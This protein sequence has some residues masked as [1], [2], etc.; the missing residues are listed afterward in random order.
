MQKTLSEKLGMS[1][2]WWR[3]LEDRSQRKADS[4]SPPGPF[5]RFHPLERQEK[6]SLLRFVQRL[7][8]LF[9]F[10]GL[11]VLFDLVQLFLL[12]SL[13]TEVHNPRADFTISVSSNCKSYNRW[14]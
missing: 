1:D 8:V 4:Y 3:N 5:G 13:K 6:H 2:S 9:V 11:D 10:C 14:R 7:C 12:S